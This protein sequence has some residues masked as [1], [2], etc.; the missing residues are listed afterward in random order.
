M[1]QI[2]RCLKATSRLACKITLQPEGF[3]PQLARS[4]FKFHSWLHIESDRTVSY[5]WKQI[6]QIGVLKATT[7]H[8]LLADGKDTSL[9]EDCWL[10]G[11]ILARFAFEFHSRNQYYFV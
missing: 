7:F 3:W 6:K 2:K 1:I 9:W 5:L 4:R 8:V 11:I 10:D